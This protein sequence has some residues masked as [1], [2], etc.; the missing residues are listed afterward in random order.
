MSST[1]HHHHHHHHPEDLEAG[2][3]AS[4]K[5]IKLAF[6]LNM[7]FAIVELVGGLLSGSF[8]IVAD[9]IH[10]FGDS[11]SLALALYLQ[12]KSVQGPSSSLTYGYKRYS[13][14]SS[15]V[16]GLIIV[17]GSLF[18]IIE[19]IPRLM[20][21][22][23]VPHA[24]SMIGL[25]VLG[26]CVNGFA[27]FGLSRGHSHNEKI[28]SWHLIEDFLGWLAV[29]IG[30]LIIYFYQIPWIDPALAIAIA[31]FVQW[32][33]IKNLKDPLRIILQTVPCTTDL[34]SI[35]QEIEK[36]PGVEHI[37][38][39]HAWSLDGIQHVLT[40]HLHI[41]EQ[42]KVHELKNRVREI[43]RARGYRFVTIEVGHHHDEPHE[44]IDAKNEPSPSSKSHHH[45][46]H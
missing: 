36:V 31:V 35:R 30:A 37:V 7:L 28:L 13:V 38:T 26:L 32:N 29:L 43:V 42:V 46:H 45:H 15:L 40:T 44:L 17:V 34:S 14:L 2:D 20:H 24:P 1:H 9:A 25:A 3:A 6:F 5:R 41:G 33:V 12:K 11:L 21:P 19:S 27:A 39:L 22:E 8:A 18:V 16:S 4:I 23:G 10:D